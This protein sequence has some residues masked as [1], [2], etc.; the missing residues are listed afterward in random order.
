[1]ATLKLV[2]K[3]ETTAYEIA[4]SSWQPVAVEDG[5]GV[6]EAAATGGN[7]LLRYGSPGPDFRD[8]VALHEG[9]TREIELALPVYARAFA[10]RPVD[11]F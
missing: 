10:D 2:R 8:E 5:P 11:D 3:G 7:V 1:M 6:V 9:E 4:G